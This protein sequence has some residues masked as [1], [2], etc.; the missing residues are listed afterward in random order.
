MSDNYLRLIPTDPEFVPTPASAEIARRRLAQLVPNADSVTVI[1]RDGVAFIDQGSNFER[2]RCPTCKSDVDEQWWSERM[3]RAYGTDFSALLVSVPC[4]GATVSLND[5][6]Y[7]GPAGFAKFVLEAM[8]P[9][10]PDLTEEDLA[11]LVRELGTPLR[12]IWA[13]Y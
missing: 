3:N 13:H 9:N 2:I 10:V 7:E 12:A 8:N 5:L 1:V 6:I 4:C 11:E